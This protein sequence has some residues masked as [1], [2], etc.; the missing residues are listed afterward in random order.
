[1]SAGQPVVQTRDLTKKYG[2]FVALDRLTMT[3]ERG[4]APPVR[5]GTETPTLPARV[6][7]VAERQRVL[8]APHFPAAA[9]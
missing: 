4:P 2:K 3:V 9:V 5:A 1:M 8:E 7:F 6:D